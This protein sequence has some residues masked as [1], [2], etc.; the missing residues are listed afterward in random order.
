MEECLFCKIINGEIPAHKV[1]EDGKVLA[2]LDVHP[3]REGHTLVIPKTHV[4][5]FYNLNE[6]HY[7]P[8]MH[9]VQKIAKLQKEVLMPEKVGLLVA[10]WDV[11]H[12]H[13]HIVP[14]QEPGDLTSKM[15]LE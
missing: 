9:A 2:F 3:I 7:T 14:M 8:L 10:G 6:A 12:A 4:V 1:Y 15:I 5:D 11:P 13:I